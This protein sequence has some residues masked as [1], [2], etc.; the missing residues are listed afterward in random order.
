MRRWLPIVAAQT[1]V[2]CSGVAWN[3]EV[4]TTEA[5]R[6]AMALS[7][8]PGR[9]T[10]TGFTT[11][12]GNPTQKIREGGQTEF[13]YRDMTN[14]PGWYYPQFGD[15]HNYVIVTFQYG[16][17]AAVRTSDGIDC[18]GTFP[19]RPPN[20]LADNPATVRLV[21][22]CAPVLSAEEAARKGPIAR[23]MDEISATWHEARAHLEGTTSEA[24]ATPADDPSER[25][26]VTPDI[27]DP[28][29]KAGK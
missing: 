10:E 6:T 27:Y 26:G 16:L 23:A 12:W 9:T 29:G 20:Y 8:V 4:A 17:A 15:S 28:S 1:L 3:T 11:R 22:A 24:G 2:A 14:L 21:G 19:P 13:V 18:R 25:P 7:V 5:A